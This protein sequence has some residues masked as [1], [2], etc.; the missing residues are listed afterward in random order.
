MKRRGC[1]TTGTKTEY[2]ETPKIDAN[3]D[4]YGWE[5][6]AR[7]T[8][9][10]TINPSLVTDDDV[11]ALKEAATSSDQDAIR[12]MIEHLALIK[13]MANSHIKRTV[14]IATLARD[15][16][17]AG[18]SN[19]AVATTCRHF[20]Q[21][22]EN[23]FF[24]DFGQFIQHAK[25]CHDHLVDLHQQAEYQPPKQLPPQENLAPDEP[26]EW[27]P[28]PENLTDEWRKIAHNIGIEEPEELFETFKKSFGNEKSTDW[29][30]RWIV[31]CN[32][33]S[34]LKGAK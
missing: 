8:S 19:F 13:P 2:F 24:P 21:S 15:L 32:V 22:A 3:G 34:F 20:R 17:D 31:R 1:W 5:A 26:E 29:E 7:T 25:Q 4:V 10:D 28:F 6:Q 11:K 16:F 27:L 18:V 14:V 30:A 12:T 9:F 23:N 33:Q